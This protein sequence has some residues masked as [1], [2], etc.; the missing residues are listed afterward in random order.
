MQNWFCF[1]V[2]TTSK[3]IETK[4]YVTT[5]ELHTFSG[6]GGGFAIQIDFI[7]SVVTYLKTSFDSGNTQAAIVVFSTDLVDSTP[8]LRNYSSIFAF[9]DNMKHTGT[10]T[11]LVAGLREARSII[12]NDS[13]SRKEDGH[14]RK[15]VFFLTDGEGNQETEL[16]PNMTDQLKSVVSLGTLSF[17]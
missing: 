16:Y 5:L 7:K 13:E 9:L 10:S 15:L 2:E 17:G 6:G 1:V 12:T 8:F 3:N 14:V 4:V 11:N